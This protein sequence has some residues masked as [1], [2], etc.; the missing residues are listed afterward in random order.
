MESASDFLNFAH[1][2][3]KGFFISEFVMNKINFILVIKPHV[4]QFTWL[5]TELYQTWSNLHYS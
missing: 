5:S 1:K 4:V 2:F 3:L